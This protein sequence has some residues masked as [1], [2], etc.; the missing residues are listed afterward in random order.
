[1]SSG[2]AHQLWETAQREAQKLGMP[3]TPAAEAH[4]KSLIDE[5]LE[6][7][8]ELDVETDEARVREAE[9]NIVRFVREMNIDA[10]RRGEG[11]LDVDA[12]DAA[13]GICPL[14][15]YC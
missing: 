10:Q 14:W 8:E 12:F 5:G 4:L 9:R 1:M 13:M 2:L 11:E 7:M 3:I 6:R 15:P